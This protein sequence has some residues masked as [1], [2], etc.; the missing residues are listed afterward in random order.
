MR[1]LHYAHKQD[2][3]F[4][5]KRIKLY[6]GV[7]SVHER[8]VRRALN[9]YGYHYRQARLPTEN[10]LKLGIKFAKDIKKVL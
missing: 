9:K 6:S 7:S 8:T 1:S 5:S 4:T 2:G 10:D 3:N